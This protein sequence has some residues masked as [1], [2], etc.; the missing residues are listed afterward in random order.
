VR[1]LIAALLIGGLVVLGLALT[2]GGGSSSSAGLP[3]SAITRAAYTTSRAP[4]FRTAMTINMQFGSQSMGLNAD[5]YLQDGGRRG[6]LSMMMGGLTIRE[7]FAYPNVYVQTG[8]LPGAGGSLGSGWMKVDVS[9]MM[10]A[11]GSGGPLASSDPTQM[12]S[13]LQAAGVSTPVGMDRVRGVLTTHYHGL[14]D[15]SRYASVAPA[16]LRAAAQQTAQFLS[17][18]TGSSG[19][20]VDV[21]VDGQ[22]RVRRIQSSLSLCT[23]IAPITE[24]MTMDFFDFGPQPGVVTPPS[25]QVT[26]LTGRLDS[27]LSGAMSSLSSSGTSGALSQLTG[28][29]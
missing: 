5:G 4:G 17:R 1:G 16:R 24:S 29:C 20:P 19:L 7:V 9:S 28:S 18:M 26:D 3:S 12:L 23:R 10:H 13:F 8:G 27:A 25:N 11:V 14:E 22:Q 21:W 15:L 6:E 2:T